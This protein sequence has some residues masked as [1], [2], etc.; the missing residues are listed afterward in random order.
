MN[1][2][3]EKMIV[4]R[5]ENAWWVILVFVF[6]NVLPLL[7]FFYKVNVSIHWLWVMLIIY[8]SGDLIFIP[9]MIGNG[10]E[11]YDDC[12][13]FYYG[14]SKEIIDIKDIK[15]IKKSHNPI[16]SSANSLDRIYISTA[17]KNLYIAL[18]NNAEFL[19]IIIERM[20][21]I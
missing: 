6:Y 9:I 1:D 8:Y 15:E 19:A 18:K 16:A 20:N 2:K 14:F 7:F 13:V 5:G 12:F 3:D 10:I 21:G 11:L 4:F 17:K